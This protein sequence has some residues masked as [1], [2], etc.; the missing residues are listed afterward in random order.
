MP[1]PLDIE[2][3]SGFLI[4]VFPVSRE[5]KSASNGS[6]RITWRVQSMIRRGS[7]KSRIASK[8]DGDGLNFERGKTYDYQCQQAYRHTDVL[9]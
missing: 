7:G 4:F 1:E 6:L 8:Y 3:V 5:H 2:R 9:F